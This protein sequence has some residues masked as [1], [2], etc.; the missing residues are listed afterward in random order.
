MATY[1][2]DESKA[3]D[4]INKSILKI[5]KWV[6]WFIVLST[7][8]LSFLVT[9]SLLLTWLV[10]FLVVSIGMVIIAYFSLNSTQEPYRGLTITLNAEQIICD[11]QGFDRKIINRQDIKSA[12]ETPG[13]GIHLETSDSRITIFIPINLSHYQ[14]LK[15]EL[16]SMLQCQ[17]PTSTFLGVN[18]KELV[19]V[20]MFWALFASL[21]LLNEFW[22]P[23]VFL[24][25]LLFFATLIGF[26]MVSG[27]AILRRG[28]PILRTTNSPLYWINIVIQV[29]L[30]VALSTGLDF[31]RF[32]Q[33]GSAVII[34]IVTV[35]IAWIATAIYFAS[36]HLS[37]VHQKD[38]RT[39]R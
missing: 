30:F 22:T 7:I 5:A 23:I 31:T 15:L 21:F 9:S 38:Q 16:N 13:N 12:W 28:P 39:D 18:Y 24:F 3:R 17:I 35:V 20:G 27:K 26:E 6:G 34:C 11:Q 33:Y 37:D 25:I 36:K 1:T 10:S 29:A 14:E 32:T 8:A 2:F 4:Q 19:P